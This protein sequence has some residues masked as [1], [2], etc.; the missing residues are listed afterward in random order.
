MR[1]LITGGTAFVSKFS[2]EYFVK[3]GDEVYVLNRNSRKQIEGARLINCDRT[4]LGNRL[5]GEHFDC[6]Y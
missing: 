4:R 2:T 5:N 1:I 6:V 3:K